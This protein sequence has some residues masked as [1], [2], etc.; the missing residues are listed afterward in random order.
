MIADGTLTDTGPLF[1]LMDARGQP[2]E[3]ARCHALMPVLAKPLVT[4][5]PC[6]T[7]ALYLCL[8]RGGWQ[9]Q[10]L[11]WSL[12]YDGGLRMHSLSEAETG[13]VA[14]LMEKYQDTPMDA[15]DASLIAL[16]ETAGY[17]QIF[18]IDSDFY[19]Y[20]LADGTALEVVPGPMS[21]GR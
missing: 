20:R 12:W 10:N 9:L 6:F 19:V 4:T 2:A 13:R 3:N 1:A 14:A 5:W 21:K 18:S 11:L 17:M 7:A 8:Q 16:A 15:A